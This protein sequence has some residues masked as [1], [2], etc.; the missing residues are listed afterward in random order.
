[1]TKY[2]NCLIIFGHQTLSKAPVKSR[3][4]ARTHLSL[5]LRTTCSITSIMARTV[6]L[7]GRKPYSLECSFPSF[8]RFSNNFALTIFLYTFCWESGNSVSRLY[9]FGLWG[10]SSCPLYRNLSIPIY[11]VDVNLPSL[12]ALF[13]K[14]RNLCLTTGHASIQISTVSSSYPAVFFLPIPK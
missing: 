1:M 4:T 6:L 7:P 3:N 2:L 10:S 11:H 5:A 14:S 9:D 13:T 8:S 12:S